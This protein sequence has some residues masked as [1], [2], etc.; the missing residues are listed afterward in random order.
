MVKGKKT[1]TKENSRQTTLKEFGLELTDPRIE[2]L[3]R[4]TSGTG[5]A[6]WQGDD[7]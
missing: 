6:D 2:F 3:W 4:Q 7:E 5:R 1:L